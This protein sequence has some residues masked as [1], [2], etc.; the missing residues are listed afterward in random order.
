MASSVWDFSRSSDFEAGR[1]RLSSLKNGLSRFSYSHS[2]ARAFLSFVGAICRIWIFT[3]AFYLYF[4][5]NT[6]AAVTAPAG[7]NVLT[8]GFGSRDCSLAC[9]S[10]QM[11]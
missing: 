2:K 9:N 7:I 5:R 11:F 1:V 8:L 4:C 10:C 3:Q 6:V